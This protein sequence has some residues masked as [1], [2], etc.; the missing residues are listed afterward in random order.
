[1]RGKIRG[2]NLVSQMGSDSSQSRVVGRGLTTVHS[3][4]AQGPQH[5]HTEATQPLLGLVT[6]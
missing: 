1:M 3:H 4:Q 5:R 6:E 2:S